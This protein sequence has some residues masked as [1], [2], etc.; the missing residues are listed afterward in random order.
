MLLIAL[1]KI[2]LYQ[3]VRFESSSDLNSTCLKELKT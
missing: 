2:K 3:C 1:N